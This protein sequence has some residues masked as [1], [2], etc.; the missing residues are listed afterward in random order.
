MR[1][2]RYVVGTRLTYLTNEKLL[3]RFGKWEGMQLPRGGVVGKTAGD[4]EGKL[5]QA[6]RGFGSTIVSVINGDRVI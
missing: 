3:D 2:G 6:E 4:T 1:G 5:T